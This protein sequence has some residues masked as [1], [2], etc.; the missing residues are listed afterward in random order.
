MVHCALPALNIA[1][2]SST[3]ARIWSTGVK[4]AATQRQS[5]LL[6]LSRKTRGFAV[7]SF[8]GFSNRAVRGRL[9]PA[10]LGAVLGRLPPLAGGA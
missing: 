3:V 9:G 2:T 1:C 8:D 6:P 5:T 10:P 4:V 7:M